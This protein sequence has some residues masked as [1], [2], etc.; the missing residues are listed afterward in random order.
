MT[1]KFSN[2]KRFDLM[3]VMSA[4]IKPKNRWRVLLVWWRSKTNLARGIKMRWKLM[5]AKW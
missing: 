2:L 3:M 1:Q 4:K 5:R